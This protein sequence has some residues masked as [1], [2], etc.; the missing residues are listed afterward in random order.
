MHLSVQLYSEQVVRLLFEWNIGPQR[1]SLSCFYA[2]KDITVS[3][4]FLCIS[5]HLN[6]N[7]T[8]TRLRLVSETKISVTF[9]C[10]MLGSDVYDINL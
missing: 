8:G 10:V 7:V 5:L 1:F 3:F 4:V 2:L 6:L 9:T